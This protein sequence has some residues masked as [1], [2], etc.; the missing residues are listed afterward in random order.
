MSINFQG[1]IENGGPTNRFKYRS[2]FVC[3]FFFP[4]LLIFIKKIKV[5]TYTLCIVV[6][7]HNKA[8]L[9]KVSVNENKYELY[10]HT[11][12]ENA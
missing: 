11:Q 8:P 9:I 2:E 7:D 3:P 6:K 12:R 1:D 5:I 4:F 10:S